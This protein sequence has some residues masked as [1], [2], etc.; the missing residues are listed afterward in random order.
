MEVFNVGSPCIVRDVAI[1]FGAAAGINGVQS[2]ADVE[3]Y[4]GATV[5]NGRATLGPLK[6]RL[7]DLNANLQL[8]SH[9]INT[10]TLPANIDVRCDSGR[11]V[12]AFR[13]LFNLSQGSCTT[14]YTA[15]F[16]CDLGSCSPGHS[17][18]DAQ[19]HGVVDVAT[20]T[21]FGIP[22][23]PLYFRGSWILRACVQPTVSVN[24]SG[25]A[26]PCGFVSL[27]YLAPGQAGDF[28]FAMLSGGTSGI[29]TPWGLVPLAPDL[30]WQ[31]FM[32]PARGLLIN[33]VGVFNATGNAF[34]ALQ[35]PCEQGLR[36]QD[37]Y[38]AFFTWR[39]PNVLVPFQSISSASA[40]IQ[41]R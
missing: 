17:L 32:G 11:P 18:M 6:F 12:V 25:N 37:W 10:Y 9:G 38:A 23:C 19:G 39:S 24:W 41:I 30:V 2:V 40:P 33:G 16:C 13:M 36:G 8:Q 14:G 1:M 21:G 26:T 15:N 3:I 28:Y 4:D 7:S 35:I 31:L 27:N 5:S 34:G 22:L 20:Y 29:P